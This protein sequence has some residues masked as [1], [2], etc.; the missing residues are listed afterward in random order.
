M[1][2]TTFRRLALALLALSFLAACGGAGEEDDLGRE[3]PA[4]DFAPGES[5]ASAA[6]LEEIEAWHQERVDRLAQEEGWLSLAGLF[7]LQEGENRFG[8]AADNDLVFPEGK[9]PVAMGVLKR[10]GED[11]TLI[12]EDGVKVQVAEEEKQGSF[13]LVSDAA[14]APTIVEYGPLLFHVIQRGEQV[15]IRLKDRQH[16]DL[17]AFAGVERFPVREQWKVAARFEPYDPPKGIPVPNV[18]GTVSDIPSPGAVVFESGGE[19]FRIDALDGGPEELFLIYG[20]ETNRAET[21]GGGRFLYVPKAGE[22]G[23]LE[24]DFNRSVNPPCAF[25]PFATCPLP[26]PSNKLAL[27]IDAGEI[28]YAGG[29]AH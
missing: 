4:E 19:T 29:P 6:Y 24:V 13:P 26:P 17:E 18:L 9:A 14:G 20:D 12:L 5:L 11:V 27:R 28:R 25:T 7:W 2:T 21:Y 16:P 8:A 22:D 1:F 10:A 3:S 15:G 23:T